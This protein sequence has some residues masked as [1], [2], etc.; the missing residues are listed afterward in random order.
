MPTFVCARKQKVSY[1]SRILINARH[2]K[3]ELRVAVVEGQQVQ[4][5]D[6][7]AITK[8]QTKAYV[9]K[10]KITRIEPSL[11][12]C[13]VD[14]GEE[15][16]GF[17]P[18]K[19]ISPKTYSKQP[20]GS[21]RP[22]I[23]DVMEEGQEIIVQVEKI[24]RG[25]KGAALSTYLTL[26]GSYLVLMPNT[27]KSGGIS[28]RIDGQER[29]ELM[30]I[31]RQL[32]TPEQMGIIIRTASIGKSLEEL[33]W[34]LDILLKLWQSINE[35]AKTKPA[36]FL[37]HQESNA[38]IR[39]LR[40]YMRKDVE[41]IIIDNEKVYQEAKSYLQLIR[42]DFAKDAS[43]VKFYQDRTPLFT[44]YQIE[45]QI[46]SIFQRNITLPGGG[47]LVIDQTEAL[48]SIDIN[49]AKATKGSD[50]ED[51]A[52]TTNLDAATEIARQLRLRDIGGLIVIDF[53]DMM[54]TENQRKVED[55]LREALSIDRA[56][57]QFG[58]ISRFG[59]LEM[60][61]QRMRSTLG[62][63]TRV[64]C[65]R[66]HGQGFIRNIQSLSLSIL[67]VIEEN[68]IKEGTKQ[69]R[70]HLPTEVATYLLN[71]KRSFLFEM[72]QTHEVSIFLI[73]HI[74]MDTPHYEIERLRHQDQIPNEASYQL[75]L[76]FKNTPSTPADVA[77]NETSKTYQPAI[78]HIDMPK[79]PAARSNEKKSSKKKVGL[80]ERMLKNIFGT[81]KKKATQKSKQDTY[82][83]RNTRSRGHSGGHRRN[84]SSGGA[85]RSYRQQ[86]TRR[87]HSRAPSNRDGA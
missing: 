27:P 46:E 77:L 8:Q 12:A 53:I 71:E 59:L 14:Y 32:K 86:N 25:N 16:H 29:T 56:K 83:D 81:T 61:R 38:M 5:L 1:M 63:S 72:E 15:R 20:S 66:C 73:P 17:L 28:R 13:F 10:G 7:E 49:S 84:N 19:D 64:L 43:K 65:P 34:D 3:Q 21:G 68:C 69:I 33:Q 22:S 54:R 23:Q 82:R 41:E 47:S 70:V 26:A 37:I 51:T 42:P 85:N 9:F 87:S 45:N 36:P 6:I 57:V 30:E 48:I 11:E 75:A 44:R 74:H 18:M 60:S 55:C 58:R 62:E 2:L 39:A 80:F 50:I 78:T 52:T 67:R 31:L 4:H 79:K 40:D 76:E 24:E 35:V